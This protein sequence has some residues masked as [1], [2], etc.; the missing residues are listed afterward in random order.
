MSVL[1]GQIYQSTRV[2]SIE[3]SEA[4]TRAPR[5]RDSRCD[6]RRQGSADRART[7]RD[8]IN[9][10]SRTTRTIVPLD[11]SGRQLEPVGRSH[12]IALLITRYTQ[13]TTNTVVSTNDR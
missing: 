2:A 5:H 3:R 7:A 1:G 8:R 12:T 13:N 6:T 10:W 11:T 4:S 9:T